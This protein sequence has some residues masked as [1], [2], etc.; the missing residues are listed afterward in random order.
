MSELIADLPYRVWDTDGRELFVSVAGEQRLDGVWEGWLEFVPL[1]DTEPLLTPTETTQSNRPALQHWAKALEET[2]VQG[3]LDRATAASGD[4]FL[5]RRVARLSPWETVPVDDVD[6]P[7]P[8]QLFSIG[9]DTM[10]ARLNALPRPLLRNII[11]VFELNPAR[12]NL[13]WLSDTQ[14]VTFIITAVEAQIAAGTRLP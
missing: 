1:D 6:I 3:A 10:R 9:R 5:P 11:D 13:A 2:Y 4:V 8:F 7:D 12:K 14:L